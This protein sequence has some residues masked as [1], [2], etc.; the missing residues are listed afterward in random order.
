MANEKLRKFKKIKLL[1]KQDEK[2]LIKFFNI[3]NLKSLYGLTNIDCISINCLCN[4]LIS[5]FMDII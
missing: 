3:R 5:I 1:Q 2:E 4:S